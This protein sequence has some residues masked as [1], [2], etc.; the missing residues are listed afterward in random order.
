LS[1]IFVSP[2]V[3]LLI[4]ENVAGRTTE[5]PRKLCHPRG[6]DPAAFREER[7]AVRHVLQHPG[8]HHRGHRAAARK[9]GIRLAPR[10][11]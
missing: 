10:T 2:I 9:D 1:R 5:R 4:D 8:Q 11:H 6:R 3:I 7:V